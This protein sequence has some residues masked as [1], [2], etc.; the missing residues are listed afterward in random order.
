MPVLVRCEL[1]RNGRFLAFAEQ[2][3]CLS[4]T[5]WPWGGRPAQQQEG[6]LATSA[7]DGV[8]SPAQILGTVG[9]PKAVLCFCVS[10]GM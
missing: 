6:V 9:K 4:W 7:S 3:V 8:P 5:L 2:S 10:S 1:Q